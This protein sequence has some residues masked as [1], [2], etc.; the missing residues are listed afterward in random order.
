MKAVNSII[1]RVHAAVAKPSHSVKS[2]VILADQSSKHNM[3]YLSFGPRHLVSSE[4]KGY[5]GSEGKAPGKLL[6]GNVLDLRKAR[7]II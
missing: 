5:W 4:W 2:F 3:S 6:R 7:F 1:W